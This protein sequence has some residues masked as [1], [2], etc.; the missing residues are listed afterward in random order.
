MTATHHDQA[1]CHARARPPA[2]RHRSAS[3][4]GAMPAHPLPAGRESST[5]SKFRRLTR[6]EFIE[7]ERN[8]THVS[9]PAAAWHF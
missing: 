2:V 1:R 8:W 9:S 5:R 7:R 6:L 4:T 3:A